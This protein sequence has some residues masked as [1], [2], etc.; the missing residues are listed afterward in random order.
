MS[1][2]IKQY[3]V[4][5]KLRWRTEDVRHVCVLCV[6]VCVSAAAAHMATQQNEAWN[7]FFPT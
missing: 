3:L 6:Y 4:M 2:A 1:W 7:T 5:Y